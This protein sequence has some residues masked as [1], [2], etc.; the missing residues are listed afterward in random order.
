ML[1]IRLYDMAAGMREYNSFLKHLLQDP[2][3]QSLDPKDF[4]STLRIH[5]VIN[6]DEH[7]QLTKRIEGKDDRRLVGLRIQFRFCNNGITNWMA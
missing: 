4:A 6:P 5:G 7:E 1:H 2:D 3:L